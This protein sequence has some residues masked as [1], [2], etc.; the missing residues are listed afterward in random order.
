MTRAGWLAV[1]GSGAAVL[2][3]FVLLPSG[4]VVAAHAHVETWTVWLA[5]VRTAAIVAAWVW[6]DAL[7]A[8]VPGITPAGAGYLRERRRF[9]IG[10]LLAVEVLLVQNVAGTLWALA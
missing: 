1:V 7:V 3:A 5:A 4:W 6:W 2:A 8:L 10:A 9:W